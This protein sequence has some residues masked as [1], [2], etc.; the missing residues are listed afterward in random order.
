MV[1]GEWGGVGLGRTEMVPALLVSR[2]PLSSEHGA[3][4]TVT[5]CLACE[6]SCMT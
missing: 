5:D 2:T 3:C 6:L 1:D 4:K